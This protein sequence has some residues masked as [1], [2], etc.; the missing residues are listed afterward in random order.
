[1]M[2]ARV[3]A[4][5]QIFRK[6][7]SVFVKIGQGGV[8]LNRYERPKLYMPSQVYLPAGSMVY[9]WTLREALQAIGFDVVGFEALPLLGKNKR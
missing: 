1:M 2:M 7:K 6:T 3:R 4:K 9:Y 5:G 8:T